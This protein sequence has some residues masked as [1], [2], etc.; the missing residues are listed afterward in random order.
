[1]Y[2]EN[3][4]DAAWKQQAYNDKERTKRSLKKTELSFEM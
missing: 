4:I 1:M 3:K 2:E